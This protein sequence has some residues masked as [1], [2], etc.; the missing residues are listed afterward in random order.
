MLKIVICSQ[1]MK[2]SFVKCDILIYFC[3]LSIMNMLE[4]VENYF[5][6]YNLRSAFAFYYLED[7]V[8]V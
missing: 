4:C 8:L 2:K 1:K 6:G 3:L 5:V 7:D